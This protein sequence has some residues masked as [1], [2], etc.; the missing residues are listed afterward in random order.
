MLY[1][2]TEKS[3]CLNLNYRKNYVPE[4]CKLQIFKGLRLCLTS[5]IKMHMSC[6]RLFSNVGNLA[7]CSKRS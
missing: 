4:R 3:D 1:L 2:E 5:Y 6:R 7:F